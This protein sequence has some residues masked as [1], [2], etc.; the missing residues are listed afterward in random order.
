MRKGT[1]YG[2]AYTTVTGA[3]GTD[4]MIFSKAKEFD[5]III[6][7]TEFAKVT[8]PQKT[9]EELENEDDIPKYLE[10][11]ELS[12]FLRTAQDHGYDLDYTMLQPNE[13]CREIRTR[14][15]KD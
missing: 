4:R 13:Q 3:H 2:Y 15:T 6:D 7:P 9:V 14:T 11:E 1:E 10:K 12:L 5:M 8:R